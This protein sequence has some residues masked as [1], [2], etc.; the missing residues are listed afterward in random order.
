MT[1][2][3]ADDGAPGADRGGIRW[4]IRCNARRRRLQLRRRSAAPQR[5]QDGPSIKELR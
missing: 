2:F 4:C 5:L 1:A 3:A